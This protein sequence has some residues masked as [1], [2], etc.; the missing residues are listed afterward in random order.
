MLSLSLRAVFVLKGFI[1]CVVIGFGLFAISDV[2]YVVLFLCCLTFGWCV[3][4]KETR[5]CF[6]LFFF[7][8][9]CWFSFGQN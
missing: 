5:C 4:T 9:V 2:F 7:F 3:V 1:V 8:L 6:L